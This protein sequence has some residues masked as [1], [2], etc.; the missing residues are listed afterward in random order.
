MTGTAGSSVAVDL[1]DSPTCGTG[2][3]GRTYLG[4]QDVTIGDVEV[5]AGDRLLLSNVL[6]QWC[7]FN[8]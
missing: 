6:F 8:E 3:A 5:S 2:G 7:I 1:F 4:T